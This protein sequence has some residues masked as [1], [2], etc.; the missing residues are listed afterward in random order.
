VSLSPD[1]GER[2]R[3][4][5]DPMPPTFVSITPRFLPD[6][7]VRSRGRG[8]ARCRKWLS[9]ILCLL[10][11]GT[12]S[13]VRAQTAEPLLPVPPVPTGPQAPAAPGQPIF[14]GETV[15]GRARPEFNPTGLRLGSFFWFPRAELDEAYNDNIFATSRSTTSDLITL[16][17]PSFDLLS[18]F[19][20][21]ALNLHGGA[22]F[23][24][25]A[26]HSAQ[27]TEDGFVAADG[28]FDVTAGS[29]FYGGATLAH[30]HLPRTSPNQPGNAAEPVTYNSFEANAGYTQS[31][32]RF[33]YTGNVAVLAQRYNA[34][35]L[36]GGGLSPQS[37][38][39]VNIYQ[40][41]LR[42]NYEL[43]PDYLGYLRLSENLRTYPKKL[44][45]PGALSFNSLGY[46]IDLGLQVLPFGISYGE[47]YVGYLRQNFFASALSSLSGIDIGG[48]YIWNVTRLTTLT[49]SAQRAVDTSNPSISNTGAGY[50]SSQAMLTIDHE[51]LR[52]LLLS[53]NVGYE[54]DAYAEVSRTD[55]IFSAGVAVKYLLNRNLYLGG[56]YTYN[57]RESSG[58]ARGSPYAQSIVMARVGTQF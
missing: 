49:F 58:S 18:N 1:P 5:V 31:G 53:A 54:N 41:D 56:S 22:A 13:G 44:P 2:A 38:N 26:S 27:N 3:T 8:F 12:P 30:F 36:I 37:A 35:P 47:I 15:M 21:K 42:L 14:P 9:G 46:R 57:Q 4:S 33:G 40:A 20:D 11:L 7:G 52:N 45:V 32:L 34:V 19:P 17:Q 48:R 6:G 55:N 43:V 39:D 16:I 50:L 28:R 29:S 51:L 25:Y 10:F 23:Q 24:D